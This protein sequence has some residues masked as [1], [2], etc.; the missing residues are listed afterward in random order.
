[1]NLGN[2]REIV[3]VELTEADA[4]PT[5]RPIEQPQPKREVTEPTKKRE[6]VP[7]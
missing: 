3:E 7:A 1:M 4:P 2:P 6:L 5:H